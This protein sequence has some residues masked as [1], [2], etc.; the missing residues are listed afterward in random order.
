[1]MLS[2]VDYSAKYCSLSVPTWLEGLENTKYRNGKKKA[3]NFL[4]NHKV[5]IRGPVGS[6]EGP[7]LVLDPME[8]RSCVPRVPWKGFSC[9]VCKSMANTADFLQWANWPPPQ[10]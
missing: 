3:R 1:M 5:P 8:V 7:W 2:T 6:I 9:L 10:D 4:K